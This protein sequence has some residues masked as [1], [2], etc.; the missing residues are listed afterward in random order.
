[1]KKSAILFVILGAAGFLLAADA[2]RA[3]VTVGPAARAP[4]L[5][6]RMQPG[7]WDG[8]AAVSTFLE[9]G[10]GAV[11]TPGTTAYLQFDER[12]LYV[13]FRCV[14]L[15]PARPRA[16]RR[17]HDDRAFEDDAVQV[18]LA[19]EDMAAAQDSRIGFG[20]YA[21][22][23]DTWYKDI[24]A[25]YEFTVNAAGSRTEARNEVRDW[26]A[27]WEAS[28]GREAGA[29]V[30]EIAIPFASLG[31]QRP[32]AGALWGLNLFR[33]RQPDASGWV[34]PAFGGYR[35]LPLGA[36]RL[37][38][39]SPVVRQPLA[40]APAVGANELRLEVLNPSAAAVD[41]E[42]TVSPSGG[43][44]AS[45]VA[46][47]P[48]GGS[49]TLAGRY[50]LG[51]WGDVRAAY[52][53]TRK[54]DAV[55]LLSGFLPR[56]RPGPQQL[57]LRYYAVSGQVEGLLH[58]EEG[59][60]ATRALLTLRP[61]AGAPAEAA[62]DLAGGQGQRLQLP[63]PGQPG[64]RLEARLQA[65][66]AAGKT[67]AERTLAVVVAA[68]PAWLGTQAGLP[69]GVLP[70]WT[71]IQVDGKRVEMLGKSFV[72][73]D[74]A[75]P[76]EARTAAGEILADPIGLVVELDGREARWDA[77]ECRVVESAADHVR[78]ESV[79]RQAALDLR[80]T[81]DLDYDGFCWTEI[82]LIPRSQVTVSR[83]ALEIPLR[84]EVAA[85]AYEEHAQAAHAI[86]PLGLCRPLSANLWIG[87][88]R[89]G[90]AFM[91]ESLEWGQ[92]KDRG[93]QVE[94][95]PERGA[96]LWRST[97]ID[98]PT[99]LSAPYA[100]TFAL[101][102]TPAKPV[103]LRKS[104]IFHGAYYGIEEARAGGTIE[105]PVNRNL[106]YRQGTLECWVKPTFDPT[107]AYD[108]A[109]DRSR[110]NRQFLSVAGG[111]QGTGEILM[112]YYNADDRSL[113]VIKRDSA[114]K[115]PL[116]LGSP[117][118]L[119]AGQWSYVGL[120]WGETLR[121]NVNGT[122]VQAEGRGLLAGEPAEGS[123]SITLGSFLLDE[124][125]ISTVAR[126]LAEVPSGAPAADDAT[127]F[128]QRFE[129][130][131]PPERSGGAA[132]TVKLSACV[133][134]EGRFGK[135]L[136]SSPETALDKL[137][138]EGKRIVI[139][140][141][142]WARYQGYPD[143]EQIPKL[144]RIAD[145]C[146]ARGMLFLVYFC[147]LM[148]D[149]APEW[150]GLQSDFLALPERVWYHRDDVKQDCA[151]SCVNGPYG[152]LLLD[153]IAKLAD[154][155]GID[156]VYM[157]GTTVP[158]DCTNPTH[159][160]CGQY[161]DDGT[162]MAHIPIRAT[163]QFMKRLRSIFAQRRQEFFLDAHTGGAINAATQSFCDG[164]YDG[165]TLARYKAGY[166][167]ST[168]TFRAA[169][170]GAPFGFRGEFLPNRHTMD[171]ALAIA[172]VH[173]TT[174]R[175]QPAAVD[176]ALR[177]YED[178][179][180]TFVPYWEDSKLYR[181]SPAPV[182]GSLYLKADRALLVLGSQT[183]Q[184]VHCRVELG[185]LLRQLPSGVTATDPIDRVPL[186]LAEKG[187]AIDLPGRG[188][189]LIELRQPAAP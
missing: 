20:G 17:E 47:I 183:E 174:T 46:A 70:P 136:G 5:D 153:G 96:T 129:T 169:Y 140:H 132:D 119:P 18:F 104:H 124:L 189:R 133:P 51:G 23:Y 40:T 122:T 118:P 87:N 109:A 172:L 28:V 71:P 13:A 65:L 59:A 107:E 63:V 43:A 170:V 89:C 106:D 90:L 19:P 167:L 161:R 50:D 11:A 105:F 147:Q 14:E 116:V 152:D 22:A 86:S 58:L 185:R 131:G 126:P 75:L 82:T 72:Y 130:L 54:G 33:L 83:F 150:Q 42:L 52:A 188:W 173:D 101:Q 178:I 115:Y 6:G 80:V 155:A 32:A 27:P 128:L 21:G 45:A 160:G 57:E 2:E 48:A 108:P 145:A 138:A 120:S 85:F 114:G 123:V 151:V 179:Q 67:I 142:D 12:A 125:R 181:V 95:L 137:A 98:T 1:M 100:A 73:A 62:A 61:P 134:A 88:D 159:P 91:A 30:A 26:D 39:V 102:V 29:W 175:G 69:L 92:A 4:I 164:Y 41:V 99:V 60:T 143:L 68:R 171:Q 3:S 77:R 184:P 186:T 180:T 34:F 31:A 64:D 16:S 156:G 168:D 53:V 158:W 148:S 187:L 9:A 24:A 81:A 127:V 110:Y 162:Y 177:D 37:A 66:D 38:G 103:A 44:A 135:A 112:L 154:A 144:R 165:E 157:D 76:C 97:F 79:W 84:R 55:P 94:I 166:R 176:L 8:A 139:F 74:L 49:G 149:A 182:L 56:Q 141:E 93:R 7:E 78:L 25:Y 163:R 146:H 117:A 15:D 36:V 10:A 35:P 121:L 113:R 111:A